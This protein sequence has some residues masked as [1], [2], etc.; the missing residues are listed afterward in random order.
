MSSFCRYL[1]VGIALF[2]CSKTSPVDIDHCSVCHY[3]HGSVSKYAADLL[4]YLDINLRAKNCVTAINIGLKKSN[5]LYT[6]L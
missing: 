6:C 2:T 4:H 3:F 5:D 1:F